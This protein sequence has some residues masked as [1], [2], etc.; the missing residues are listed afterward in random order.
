MSSKAQ[1]ILNDIKALPPDEQR[2]VLDEALN[3][4]LR[5]REWEQ[6]QARLRDLQSRHAG[7]GLLNRMLETRAEERSRG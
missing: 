4:R 5:S 1:T 3:L 2:Q 6:Q 7:S